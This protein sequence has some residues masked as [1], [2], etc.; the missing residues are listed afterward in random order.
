MYVLKMHSCVN[1]L[2]LFTNVLT[3]IAI[4]RYLSGMIGSLPIRK[5]PPPL[6]PPPGFR[7][8]SDADNSKDKK[9]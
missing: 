1:V 5:P 9:I 6:G 2:C 4:L 7:R 8:S 3:L